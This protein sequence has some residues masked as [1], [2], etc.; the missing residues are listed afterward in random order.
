MDAQPDPAQFR[1]EVVYGS[2]DPLGVAAEDVGQGGQRGEDVGGVQYGPDAGGVGCHG[3]VVL[4]AAR[5]RVGRC[6]G[7]LGSPGLRGTSHQV[8][9]FDSEGW[10]RRVSM[11]MV[12]PSWLNPLSSMTIATEVQATWVASARVKRLSLLRR[13]RM[14]APS[15][16]RWVAV[17]RAS[18]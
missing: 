5:R 9:G 12:M 18:G 7:A 16:C 11:P 14:S 13:R 17:K 6:A 3:V 2:G 8:G 10:A 1:L 4:G 15:K